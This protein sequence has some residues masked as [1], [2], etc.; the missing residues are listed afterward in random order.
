MVG[1]WHRLPRVAVH[2]PS[3]KVFKARLDGALG[4][5]IW[6]VATLPLAEE[7]ELDGL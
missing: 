5:L 3:L 6:K 4:S 2:N 1:H 7:S